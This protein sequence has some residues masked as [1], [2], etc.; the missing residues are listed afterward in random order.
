MKDQLA[1]VLKDIPLREQKSEIQYM[2]A[3]V[4]TREIGN[5]LDQVSVLEE[6]QTLADD[7]QK[8][9]EMTQSES[10]PRSAVIEMENYRLRQILSYTFGSLI[11]L[12]VELFSDVELDQSLLA[13]LETSPI[14][15]VEE[16][17]TQKME[18]IIGLLKENFNSVALHQT[19]AILKENEETINRLNNQFR[20]S[21]LLI[22]RKY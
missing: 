16:S 13:L 15:W 12:F 21:N 20:K 22:G 6:E 2:Q 14:D 1:T 4:N 19:S 17:L 10:V 5:V 8:D 18:E 7:Q 3:G 9:A 11:Q